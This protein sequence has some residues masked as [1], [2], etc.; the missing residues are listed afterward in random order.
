M[1]DHLVVLVHVRRAEVDEDV[2]NEHDVHYEVDDG[3]RL[4]VALLDR[5]LDL[6]LLLLAEEEGGHVGGDDGRVDDE[7]QDDPVPHG[8]ERRVVQ[9]RA[10][11]DPR[12]LQLVL[13]E[14]VRTEGQY[15]QGKQREKGLTI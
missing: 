13:R 10:P 2:D 1:A 6:A 5:L 14:H 3:Q 11:V 9:D 12:R 7:Q 4:G 8:L 15:L